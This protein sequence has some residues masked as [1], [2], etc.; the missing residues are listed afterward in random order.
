MYGSPPIS[1]KR[2]C[3]PT[4][5]AQR[6]SGGAFASGENGKMDRGVVGGLVGVDSFNKH[7]NPIDSRLAAD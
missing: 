6:G 3:T 5:L 1:L 4:T 2:W 7:Q